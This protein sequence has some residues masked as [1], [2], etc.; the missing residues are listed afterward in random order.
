MKF[1]INNKL[2]KLKALTSKTL[3]LVNLK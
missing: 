2:L 1:G 3:T